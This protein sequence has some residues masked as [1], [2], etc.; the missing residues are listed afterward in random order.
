MLAIYLALRMYLQK[1]SLL[2]KGREGTGVAAYCCLPISSSPTRASVN[3]GEPQLSKARE[4]CASPAT[5]LTFVFLLSLLGLLTATRQ[6]QCARA[7]SSFPVTAEILQ[8]AVSIKRTMLPFS[9]ELVPVFVCILRC[10]GSLHHSKLPWGSG[11][12]YD[13]C[14]TQYLTLFIC[15]LRSWCY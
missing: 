5:G 12:V 6:E 13:A 7:E 3:T 1:Q 10:H 14:C 8:L 15:Q 9:P 2:S 4:G 11:A